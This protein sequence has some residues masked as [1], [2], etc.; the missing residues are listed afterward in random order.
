M[1]VATLDQDFSKAVAL[2]GRNLTGDQQIFQ[3]HQALLHGVLLSRKC[4]VPRDSLRGC[5]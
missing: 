4:N 3:V 5:P 1:G 2:L